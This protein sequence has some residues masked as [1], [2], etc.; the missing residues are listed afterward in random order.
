[1]TAGIAAYSI[2][3]ELLV[4]ISLADLFVNDIAEGRHFYI[5]NLRV[6]IPEV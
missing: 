3:V 4:E 1:M 2:A 6:E 5:L